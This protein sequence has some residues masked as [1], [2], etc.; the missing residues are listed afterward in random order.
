MTLLSLSLCELNK[1]WFPIKTLNTPLV[2]WLHGGNSLAEALYTTCCCLFR[3]LIQS[4]QHANCPWFSR[5]VIH[6][7]TRSREAW[8]RPA[9]RAVMWLNHILFQGAYSSWVS[10]SKWVKVKDAADPPGWIILLHVAS[11]HWP[12][13]QPLG[14]ICCH[15]TRSCSS[16]KKKKKTALA[17]RLLQRIHL[18]FKAVGCSKE[19]ND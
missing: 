17:A 9:D 2:T 8:L 19:T 5:S 14:L 3:E 13:G 6:L 1:L 11:I 15:R 16:K 4:C 7:E 18:R 10:S 12:N